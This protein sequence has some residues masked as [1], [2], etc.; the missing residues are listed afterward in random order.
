MSRR[1]TSVEVPFAV[2]GWPAASVKMWKID[3]I[4][5]Y[6]QN[7]K[8]HP[9][10]Q[11]TL[12]ADL[13]RKFGVDQPIVVDENGVILKGHGR[14]LAAIEARFEEFPVVQHV[15]LSE[16]DKIALRLADNQVPLLGGWNDE[17]IKGELEK[18]KLSDYP[19]ALLG[20]APASLAGWLDTTEGHTDP[21][22]TPEPP[23]V[24]IVRAGDLWCLGRHRLLCGDSTKADDVARVLDGAEPHLMVTDPPYGVNYD[25][26]WRNEPGKQSKTARKAAAGKVVND[27]QSEW[28]AAWELF[29]G[30]VAY[31]WHGERQSPEIVAQFPE[32]DRRNLIVWVK[33]VLV[34]SRGHYHPQHETC[35]YLVRKGKTARWSGDRKQS[36]TWFINRNRRNE[37][38]HGTQ[39]PVECMK[40]PIEN[41]SKPGDDVYEPFSGSGT[42]I[43]AGEMTGRRV[44]AI[45]LDPTYVQ[46]A[47]ERWQQFAKQQ[48]TLDG[49]PFEDVAAARRKGEPKRKRQPVKA[50]AP[51]V[52]GRK[53]SSARRPQPST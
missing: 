33:D 31:V 21:E 2:P 9:P 51:A 46:V 40:R 52:D 15:G 42:T 4:I 28:S 39:K 17:L 12:L 16:D 8:N 38:G 49:V 41:N 34:I 53:V 50:G 36:T 23:K 11:V 3:R 25:P 48:A 6:P 5:P 20:F 47:I 18:L 22:A 10:E 13:M 27:H 26:N 44:L 29:P 37:T 43:V 14:R 19:M 35:W 24:P 1:K 32:F 7:A 30:D 45:E